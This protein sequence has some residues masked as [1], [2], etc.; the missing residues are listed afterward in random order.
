MQEGLPC[1]VATL[2]LLHEPDSAAL[3]STMVSQDVVGK[4]LQTVE[5]ITDNIPRLFTY[6]QKCSSAAVA[7]FHYLAIKSSNCMGHKTIWLQSTSVI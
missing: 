3:I 7:G 1:V 2:R 5:D 4:Q 6:R